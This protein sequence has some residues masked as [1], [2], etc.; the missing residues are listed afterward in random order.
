[1]VNDVPCGHT[2]SCDESKL[3]EECVQ[4]D[5]KWLEYLQTMQDRDKKNISWAAYHAKTFLQQKKKY[6]NLSALL[7]LWRDDSKSPA[8]IKHSLDIVKDAVTCLNHGQTP[9]VAFDQPLS[10]SKKDTVASSIYIW[11][12][13]VDDGPI[14][15]RDGIYVSNW[16]LVA[17]QW[18][19]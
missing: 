11:W 10:F 17:G 9:V 5:E 2:T 7:P 6:S 3:S 15:Y 4:A 19:E 18:L 14:A 8:M 1:M 12:L 16:G 13:C